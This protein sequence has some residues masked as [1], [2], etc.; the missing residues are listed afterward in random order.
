MRLAAVGF[1]LATALSLAAQQPA[2]QKAADEKSSAPGAAKAPE[3]PAPPT[4]RE[5]RQYTYTY[6]VNGRPVPAGQ[7]VQEGAGGAGGPVEGYEMRPGADGRPVVI[8]SADERLLSGK[9]GD[10]KGERVIQR[11][12]PSGR[13]TSRQVVQFERKKMPDGSTVSTEDLYEQDVNGRMQLVERRTTVRKETASGA[14]SET[15][16]ER[17]SINGGVQ[18]VE[19]IDRIETRR[20]PSV[21]DAV[22]SRKVLDANGRLS[23]RERESSVI[24]KS[25][26]ETNTETKQWQLGTGTGQLEY[27]GRSVSRLVEKPDGSQVEDVEVYST[28]IAGTTPDLNHPNVPSLEERMHR[29]KK[30]QP[31]GKVV[32]TVSEQMRQVA[33]PSRLSGLLVTQQVTTP[34]QQGKQIQTTVSQ[35]DANGKLVPVRTEVTEEKN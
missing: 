12:D 9:A 13:P 2:G 28:K 10:Q 15:T 29:E 31:D 14:A 30:I 6:D 17:P 7:T 16:V 20:S 27:T 18:V 24:T 19:R 32:E 8:R 4:P 34:T 26:N 11:Y 21:T 22:S 5:V 35:R 33:D 25:G 23:E 1:I 3:K